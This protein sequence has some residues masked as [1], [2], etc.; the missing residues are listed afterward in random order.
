MAPLVVDHIDVEV[1]LSDVWGVE[2]ADLEFNNEV[3]GLGD[4]VEEQVDEELSLI[5]GDWYLS[6][7]ESETIS[8]SSMRVLVLSLTMADSS[9]RSWTGPVRGTALKPCDVS[10]TGSSPAT[11]RPRSRT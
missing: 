11:G 9:S 10:W 2:A 1:E 6:A 7:D 8:P 3:P 4:G 5:D